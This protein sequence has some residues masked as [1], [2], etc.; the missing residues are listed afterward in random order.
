MIKKKKCFIW[1]F[2]FFTLSLR[3]ILR[4]SVTKK[5]QMSILLGLPYWVQLILAI[6]AGA[7]LVQTILRLTIFRRALSHAGK[8]E[9]RQ[10]AYSSEMPPVSVIVYA[11]NQSEDLLR[12][13]PVILDND[14]PDFEVIVVDD[15]ST[16]DTEDVITQ[17]EQRSEHFFHTSIAQKARIVSHRK[18]AMMLG[19]KAA[20]SEII[21]MTQAQCVPTSRH[22]ISSMVRNFNPWTDVVLGPMA[23]EGRTGLMNRFYQ[24]DLFERM[25]DMMSLTLAVRPYA[26]WGHN[27]AFRKSAFFANNN[28]AFA[29]HLNIHPGEDDLFVAG[30]QH[31]NN[32]AVEC[33]EQ[34]M[35][36]NQISPLRTG[37]RKDRQNRAFTS[38]HYS[39][40]SRWVKHLDSLTRFLFV[41]PAW[42]L[43]A[44][45]TW[46]RLPLLAAGAGLLIIL[47]YLQVSFV[48]NALAAKLG[49]HRYDLSPAVCELMTPLVDLRFKLYAFFNKRDYFVAHISK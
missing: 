7:W 4:K 5:L 8:A 9:K 15:G 48:P 47:H 19:V 21:L 32:V 29:S 39:P 6:T 37:W 10:V 1:R 20:H 41:L 40:L 34:A 30:V 12:N 35:I 49:L 14:Y 13:I 11:H 3:T 2:E 36:I 18:L 26:G 38:S 46:T 45:A 27:M 17:M 16:D 44:Y 24:W 33:T 28:Q 42:A 31:H 43:L 25:N 22:W 23:F